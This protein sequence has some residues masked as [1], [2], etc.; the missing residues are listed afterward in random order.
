MKLEFDKITIGLWI[1]IIVLSAILILTWIGFFSANREPIIIQN[2]GFAVST[3]ENQ[4]QE[5]HKTNLS[6][7]EQLLERFEWLR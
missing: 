4:L 5:L 6:L 3:N 7:K 1:M 2:S